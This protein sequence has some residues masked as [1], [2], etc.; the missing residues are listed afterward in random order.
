MDY[1]YYRLDFDPFGG[2]VSLY[3]DTSYM[4]EA[5]LYKHLMS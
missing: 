4:V 1:T 2:S 3:L 5:L